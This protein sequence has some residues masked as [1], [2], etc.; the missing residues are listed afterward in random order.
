MDYKSKDKTKLSIS[1]YMPIETWLSW[2]HNM[3]TEKH[4]T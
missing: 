3:K 4:D 1:V 2:Q